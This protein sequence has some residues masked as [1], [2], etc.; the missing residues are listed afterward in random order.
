MS[1]L[2][3]V[4]DIPQRFEPPIVST[5]CVPSSRRTLVKLDC[6]VLDHQHSPHSLGE[7]GFE[8]F[9][10]LDQLFAIY[11]LNNVANRAEHQSL[12]RV[13]VCGDNMDGNM[14]SPGIVF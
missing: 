1:R 10:C 3:K 11:R 14:P 9:Q 2:L 8:L 13:F 4:K 5:S 12:F 6:I 7:P